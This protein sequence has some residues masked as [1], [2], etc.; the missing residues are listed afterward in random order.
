MRMSIGQSLSQIFQIWERIK[1][2]KFGNGHLKNKF[3]GQ[4]FLQ[5][6]RIFYLKIQDFEI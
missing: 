3:F 5:K 1:F 2:E 4:P 6:N